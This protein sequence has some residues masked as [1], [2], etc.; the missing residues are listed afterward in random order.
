VPAG[1]N[2]T[3]LLRLDVIDPVT[4]RPRTWRPANSLPGS[5]DTRDLGVKVDQIGVEKAGPEPRQ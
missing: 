1:G 5:D 2:G 3:P 4:S